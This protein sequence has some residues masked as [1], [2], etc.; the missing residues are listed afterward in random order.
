MRFQEYRVV[1]LFVT[2]VLALIAASPALSRLLVLPKAESFS[3]MWIL[4]SN[5]MAEAYPFNIT[6]GD[7]YDIFLGL[8]NRLGY[9]AYYRVEVKFRNQTQSAPSSFNRTHSSL[10][11][12]LGINS[13]VPDEVSWEL[14]IRFSFYYDYDQNRSETVFHSLTFNDIVLDLQGYSAIWNSTR[15]IFSGN[16]FFELWIF[17]TE[18]NEFYYHERFVNLQLNMTLT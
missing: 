1:F 13:F 12:L 4:G 9:A 14:P 17:N 18:T 7:D 16:L 5:H 3:E 10:P 6:R 15:Q 2:V 11:S 8:A